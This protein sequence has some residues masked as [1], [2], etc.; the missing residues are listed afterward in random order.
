M[1]PELT[2]NTNPIYWSSD[3][4]NF[5]QA[6]RIGVVPR[7]EAIQSLSLGR[8]FGRE[9]YVDQLG[10]AVPSIDRLIPQQF[11]VGFLNTQRS[12]SSAGAEVYDVRA[13]QDA[14][15]LTLA[16]YTAEDGRVRIAVVPSK[17]NQAIN[18]DDE[19]RRIARAIADQEGYGLGEVGTDT[20]MEQVSR[21][22]HFIAE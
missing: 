2:E 21:L 10:R 18:E 4:Q 5:Y 1:F 20:I 7:L 11:Q 6:G 22:F 13:P 19:T 8:P 3:A 9:G 17:G 15:Y 14:Y 12:L 16:T